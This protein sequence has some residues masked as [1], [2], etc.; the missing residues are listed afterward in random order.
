MM[1]LPINP[2]FE[3]R[4][5]GQGALGEVLS[6]AGRTQRLLPDNKEKMRQEKQS[7]KALDRQQRKLVRQNAP[8]RLPGEDPDLAGIVPGP[9]PLEFV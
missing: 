1:V 3:R 4:G 8:P 2:R 9:Q 5:I 7:A 6:G